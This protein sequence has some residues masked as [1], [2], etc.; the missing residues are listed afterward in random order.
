MRHDV[1]L[2]ERPV[3]VRLTGPRYRDS[4]MLRDHGLTTSPGNAQ[5]VIVCGATL[6]TGR[7]R[8]PTCHLLVANGGAFNATVWGRAV[9][10]C[11]S[12]GRYPDRLENH[13]IEARSR[14]CLRLQ[15]GSVSLRCN[16]FSSCAGAGQCNI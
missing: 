3:P 12:A 9:R 15:N 8:P 13:R 5:L 6:A 16:G 10:A 2:L 14:V 1:S 4:V 11:L 7:S